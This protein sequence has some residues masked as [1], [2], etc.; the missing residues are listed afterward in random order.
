MR[1]RRSF[2]FWWQDPWKQPVHHAVREI[3]CRAISC[4]VVFSGKPGGQRTGSLLMSC[5]A[6]LPR[7]LLAHGDCPVIERQMSS[8]CGSFG[9]RRHLLPAAE[10][11]TLL[12][13]PCSHLRMLCFGSD[14]GNRNAVLFFVWFCN[15]RAHCVCSASV[16]FVLC[17]FPLVCA[18]GCTP[19][20]S[21]NKFR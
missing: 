11:M 15:G 7:N 6:R 10:F 21:T 14:R 2:S 1:A 20:H 4:A 18:N 3:D 19:S 9:S 5:A 12:R 13:V 8:C 17:L 16:C